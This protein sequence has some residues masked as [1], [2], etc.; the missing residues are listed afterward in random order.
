MEVKGN[1]KVDQQATSEEEGVRKV[2]V[3]YGI[4]QS[5]TGTT[6]L[7]GPAEGCIP[8]ERTDTKKMGERGCNGGFPKNPVN[9]GVRRSKG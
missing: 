2:D 1:A 6:F 3:L 7:E 8:T 4:S 5:T 9:R